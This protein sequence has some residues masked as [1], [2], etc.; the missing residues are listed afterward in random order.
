M[1]IAALL[2][3]PAAVRADNLVTNGDFAT[4]DFTGWNTV[5]ATSDSSD[6]FVGSNSGVSFASF[7][8]YTGVLG[9]LTYYDGISQT[10]N[11]VAGT[12]YTLSFS[13]LNDQLGGGGGDFAVADFTPSDNANSNYDF[14]VFW[15]GLDTPLAEI[16]PGNGDWTL[17]SYTVVAQGN[18]QLSFYGYNNPGHDNLTN[19]SVTS[20]AATPEPSSLLLLG[21]GL[22][23]FAGMLRR[24][25]V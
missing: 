14:V 7:G 12:Q 20:G 16:N 8:A 23:G 15:N 2:A 19:V 4:G 11:T 9:D 3:L 21:T 6:N 22:V 1:G 17:Y 10:L 13:L 5:D 25:F 18:D 24:R